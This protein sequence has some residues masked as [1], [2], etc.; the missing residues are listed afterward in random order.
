[1]KMPK[2]VTP[3]GEV[4]SITPEEILAQQHAGSRQ[5]DVCVV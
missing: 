4:S 1:M 5:L 3:E 2:A